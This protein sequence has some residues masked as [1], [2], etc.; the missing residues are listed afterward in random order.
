MPYKR[1]DLLMDLF[2]DLK[3]IAVVMVGPGFSDEQKERVQK[4]DNL[5]Y[6]GEK[7]GEEVNEIYKIG[8]VFSTPG[9]IGLA[10]NEAAFWGLPVVL[11][12][13]FHAPE[14]YYMKSGIN[15]YL[16]KDENDLKR[17]T[18]ELLRDESRLNKMKEAALRIYNEEISIDKMY[19]GFIEAIKYCE[20]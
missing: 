16:A 17:F 10:M 12:D 15:G 5:Y 4:H 19:Q 8:D 18:I 2:E 13:G 3:D 6:L 1:V 14:I 7:Y 20:R 11:L 9:H